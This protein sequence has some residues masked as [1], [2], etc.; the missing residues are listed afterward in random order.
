MAASQETPSI[1]SDKGQKMDTGLRKAVRRTPVSPGRPRRQLDE[2]LL[3]E[4]AGRGWGFKRI[5]GEY[6]AMTG[7]Y[8]SHATVRDRLANMRQRS[9]R[10]E[11][12]RSAS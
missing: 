2:V 5:A 11:T 10:L 6:T 9:E 8:L 7:E 12:E 4:L 1:G 3:M